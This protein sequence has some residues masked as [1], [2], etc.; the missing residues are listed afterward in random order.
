MLALGIGG[1]FVGIGGL[2]LDI[3]LRLT[4]IEMGNFFS[5][6]Y[7][8]GIIQVWQIIRDLFNILFIFAFIF[9]GIKTIL[10][11]DDSGTRRA[12]GHIII[13]GVFVNLSLFI[14]QAIVR[15]FE[16]RCNPNL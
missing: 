13:A 6:G 2:A 11:S 16:H 4:V 1:L 12:I 5:G 8:L 7:G 9:L 3:T 14:T 10:N 15:F